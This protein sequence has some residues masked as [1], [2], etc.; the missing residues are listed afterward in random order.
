MMVSFD[1]FC[2]WVF[3]SRGGKGEADVVCRQT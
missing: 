2:F 3:L 1:P